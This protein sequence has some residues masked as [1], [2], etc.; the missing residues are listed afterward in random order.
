MW[1]IQVGLGRCPTVTLVANS[2]FL[3]PMELCEDQG[4]TEN[5]P[6]TAPVEVC[7]GFG[8]D[9][10]RIRPHRPQ[11]IPLPPGPRTGR[12]ATPRHPTGPLP[13]TRLDPTA[14]PAAH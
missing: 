14:G 3:L 10:S 8:T 13:R 6:T 4:Q 5:S 11:R 1:S 7:P 9:R 12:T 2:I